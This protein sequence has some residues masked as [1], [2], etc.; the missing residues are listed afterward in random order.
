VIGFVGV[1]HGFSHFFQLMLP[2]LFPMLK[3]AFGTG[4]AELGLVVAVFYAVSGLMQTV[5]GF[6]VDR[7]GAHR[8]LVLGLTF[9]AIGTMLYALAPSYPFL[10]VG[11]V[12]AGLGNS[13]FHPGDLA[14]LNAR[15]ST[16]RLGYAFSVHGIGGNLG[17]AAAPVF[18][19]AMAG[20]FG[21]RTALVAAGVTGLVFMVLFAM[22]KR[23]RV[24]GVVATS[25]GRRGLARDL[26]ALTRPAIVLCF[27][28]FLLYSMALVGYQT[29][30]VP[31]MTELYAVPIVAATTALT[32][33]LLGGAAG[34]LFGGWVAT[35]TQRHAR[36]AAVG[37]LLAAV[38]SLLL[39]PGNVPPT[40]LTVVIAAVGFF[41]GMI[42]P[43]RDILVREVA[44]VD[45]RG[46][47]YGFVYSG[48]DLGGLVA[49]LAF[50]VA[51]DNGAPWLV[52]A[53]ASLFML[54][55]IPTALSVVA[56][57][58]VVAVPA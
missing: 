57:R 22:Q 54:L 6:L 33:F 39:A 31:A 1:A 23:L 29:F 13:V 42:G 14:L 38:F 18:A 37:M 49:P 15:V 4:Y 36:V 47:V 41:L 19:V 8:I 44:P 24:R 11:A 25:A 26:R 35:R 55:S 5:A 16:P 2:P 52:F 21:W 20:A 27:L 40:L 51:L 28:F 7:F 17:W 56:P 46:K 53:G 3:E 50:G 48:L 34:I 58:R 45:A 43:S 30:S 9:A 12:V 10:I 32:I